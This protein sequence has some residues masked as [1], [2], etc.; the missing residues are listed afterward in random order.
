MCTTPLAA[1]ARLARLA[2][3]EPSSLCQYPSLFLLHPESIPILYLSPPYAVHQLTLHTCMHHVHQTPPAAYA[4]CLVSCSWCKSMH[5][6]NAPSPA[7]CKPCFAASGLCRDFLSLSRFCW[8][9][10]LDPNL[11]TFKHHAK[12]INT[13]LTHDWYSPPAWLGSN[14]DMLGRKIY[15]IKQNLFSSY[16]SNFVAV[17][18]K[19]CAE[20]EF[21]Q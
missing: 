3:N 2:P 4:R 15:E 9:A 10:S 13:H 18:D 6:P 19:R 14:K 20:E 12:C 8:S 21:E 17:V 7:S 16:F 11:V 1:Y 5:P